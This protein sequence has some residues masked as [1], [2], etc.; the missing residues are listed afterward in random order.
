MPA[1]RQAAA[2][3]GPAAGG[4]SRTFSIESFLIPL[5]LPTKGATT[6]NQ[7][8]VNPLRR[9]GRRGSDQVATNEAFTSQ[10]G[11]NVADR[12]CAHSCTVCR[13]GRFACRPLTASSLCTDS[14]A[15][16]SSID[17]SALSRS[18]FLM[19][20]ERR[21]PYRDEDG[22]MNLHLLQRSIDQIGA[23]AACD[24]RMHAKA[25]AWLKHGQSTLLRSC[26]AARSGSG[27]PKDAKVQHD[28]DDNNDEDDEHL[29]L[30]DLL[31]A[32]LAS[33]LASERT[34]KR[35]LRHANRQPRDATETQLDRRIS[36]KRLRAFA[37]ATLFASSDSDEDTQER[38]GGSEGESAS[39]D[40]NW[41]DGSERS[42][43]SDGSDGEAARPQE[44]ASE[45]EA[46][47]PVG[48]FDSGAESGEDVFEVQEVLAEDAEHGRFRIRWAGFGPE[49]DSWEP[50][51]NISPELVAGFRTA[52]RARREHEGRDYGGAA[53]HRPTQLW[54]SACR[55]HLHRDSFSALQRRNEAAGRT[56][57]RHA[58][59]RARAKR[60]Q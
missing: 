50:E 55:V 28:D 26:Q 7:S 22:K 1:D 15:P 21:L 41:S 33:E 38:E 25:I 49:H 45:A 12:M 13:C 56:C 34:P 9:S 4:Y 16:I 18:R 40:P 39:D 42:D 11:D 6:A 57:L 43:G 36:R 32:H 54:C 44:S 48:V 37:G 35:P 19:Q 53:G 24:A 3:S 52:K 29:T 31:R 8:Y 46:E 23:G 20:R 2:C 14:D 17:L 51:A 60:Q 10:R 30:D 58:I 47:R 59:A 5:P 27:A